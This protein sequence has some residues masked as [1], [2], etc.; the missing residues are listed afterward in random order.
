[1]IQG[2]AN[3]LYAGS[4]YALVALGLT[5]IYSAGRFLHFAHGAIYAIGAYA[6]FS[7]VRLGIP[8]LEAAGLGVLTSACAGVAVELVI[9][10]RLRNRGAT[11]VVM[12]LASLGV[13]VVVQSVL[14][15]LFGENV[16]MIRL[17]SVLEGKNIL[18]AR[19]TPIQITGI[20][21]SV[22]LCGLSCTILS[23]SS[24]GKQVRAVASDL[25]LAKS[26]GIDSNRVLLL[27]MLLASALAGFAGVF[28][29]YD[30]DVRPTMGF[31]PLL[32]GVVAAILGGVGNP[33]GA[34][35]ASMLLA[36][37]QQ[38]SVHCFSSRWQDIPVF[39]VLILVLFLRRANGVSTLSSPSQ[40]QK[41]LQRNS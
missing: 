28:C 40:L 4:Q 15:T 33:L 12:L 23:L 10:R 8:V 27:V 13:F 18:G 24:F 16:K 21:G 41:S 22:V 25:E 7:F 32:A 35:I 36:I 39:G 9:Y 20:I 5:I 2:L 29:A 19:L 6:A 30:V 26:V 34:I 11:A 38:A 14:S 31:A 3:T 1:M 37:L 17:D